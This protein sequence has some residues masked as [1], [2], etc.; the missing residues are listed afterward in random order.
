MCSLTISGVSASFRKSRACRRFAHLDFR[1][2][3]TCLLF[4]DPSNPNHRPIAVHKRLFISIGASSLV[5]SP[6]LELIIS[7][8]INAKKFG[9]ISNDS[10]GFMEIR[11]SRMSVSISK[12][13][14]VI[15]C[16]VFTS[17][18]VIRSEVQ[19]GTLVHSFSI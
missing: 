16:G 8:S 11:A 1:Y 9:G 6:F 19:R 4:I 13:R 3:R 12:S 5:S 17:L 2:H 18:D 7:L 10:S 15:S 14:V